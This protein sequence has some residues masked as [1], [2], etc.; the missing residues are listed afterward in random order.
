M[1][2]RAPRVVLAYKQK[3]EL[4]QLLQAEYASSEKTDAEFAI[5]A[6]EKL[7]F[8]IHE[9]HIKTARQAFGIPGRKTAPKDEL[10]ELRR[11]IEVLEKRFNVWDGGATQ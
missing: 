7:D 8:P 5:Y 6:T 4:A 2:A 10:S 11:R 9:N 1:T 3:V